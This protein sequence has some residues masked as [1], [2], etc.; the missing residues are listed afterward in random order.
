MQELDFGAGDCFDGVI[1]AGDAQAALRSHAGPA[2]DAF[3]SYGAAGAALLL[4]HGP[5]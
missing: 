2:F 4:R 5:S 1:L 3:F